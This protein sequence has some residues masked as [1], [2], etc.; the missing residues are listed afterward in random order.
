MYFRSES[1]E[2]DVAKQPRGRLPKR[3]VPTYTP[4]T[5]SPRSLETHFAVA[6]AGVKPYYLNDT[7]T[8][9]T[10]RAPRVDVRERSVPC[11]ESSVN[12]ISDLLR[13]YAVESDIDDGQSQ[14]KPLTI[15]NNTSTESDSYTD[16]VNETGYAS[17]ANTTVGTAVSQIK[18]DLKH[19]SENACRPKHE[20]KPSAEKSQ[21]RR[22]DTNSRRS[23]SRSES[24]RYS[25]SVDRHGSG[26]GSSN[27]GDDLHN[28]SC[29]E[30]NTTVRHARSHYEKSVPRFTSNR[31]NSRLISRQANQ[32]YSASRLV[33]SSLDSTDSEQNIGRSHQKY[34]LRSDSPIRGRSLNRRSE[35]I[36]SVRRVSFSPDPR[37]APRLRHISRRR[38]SGSDSSTSYDSDSESP[39]RYASRRSRSK[40]RKRSRSRAQMKAKRKQK[41]PQT[42]DGSS[43]FRDYLYH[44]NQIARWNGWSQ[45]EN[46]QQL[47]MSLRGAAQEILSEHTL[48]E[49]DNF[50]AISHALTQR[51]HPPERET[52]YRNEFRNSRQKRS[53]N[54]SEY[55]HYL[56]KL[57]SKAFPEIPKSARE[58]Y[59][60]EQFI[61]SLDDHELRKHVKFNRPL[62]LDEA[63]SYAV[64]FEAFEGEK[65]AKPKN[66]NIYAVASGVPMS[67]KDRIQKLEEEIQ[68]LKK[69]SWGRKGSLKDVVCYSCKE[70]GHFSKKCPNK[71]K[72]KEDEPQISPNE[73]PL[74]T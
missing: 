8:S 58:L 24:R 6:S 61:N 45:T 54:A 49:L 16:I 52:A 22:N 14:R 57:G 60:I 48:G 55:G 53:Q 69:K 66:A 50:S 25:K 70:K 39:V 71:A 32:S 74:N 72:K 31:D 43:D 11:S 46:A 44:F 1:D 41:E 34:N 26:A 40:A 5:L 38:L 21:T 37:I 51:F 17:V 63:I 29:S 7:P 65:P 13:R 28:D 62:S 33:D 15:I 68:F 20:S 59:T 73:G 42:F 64:E 19:K 35:P 23:K 56:R 27:E 12:S 30:S 4:F 18:S 2:G 36:K 3:T 9:T 67:D 47:S 10:P